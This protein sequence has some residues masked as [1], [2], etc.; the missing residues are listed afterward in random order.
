MIRGNGCTLT[1]VIDEGQRYKVRNVS[2]VGNKKFAGEEL[3][4][5]SSS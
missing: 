2:V 4:R 3:P 5:A 1:F